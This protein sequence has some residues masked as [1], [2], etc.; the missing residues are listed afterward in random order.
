MR[1]AAFILLVL[2]LVAFA[3]TCAAQQ[4]IFVKRRITVSPPAELALHD[5]ALARGNSVSSLKSGMIAS[6]GSNKLAVAFVFSHKY[7]NH[8]HDS[9]KTVSGESFSK[10]T[11][12][13]QGDTYMR[14][15][16]WELKS[17]AFTSDTVQAWFSTTCDAGVFVLTFSGAD[18]VAY[19][20]S[21]GAYSSTASVNVTSQNGWLV[22]DGCVAFD[23]ADFATGAG[24]TAYFEE[25]KID[26]VT[27]L[28]FTSSRENGLTSVTMSHGLGSSTDWA[29]VGCSI[30]PK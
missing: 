24:Q 4:T 29:S 7:S 18:S 30:V 21:A 6:G 1:I 19:E 12:R 23:V 25:Y 5:T 20:T 16:L 2:V 27:G 14:V 3:Y 28:A 8:T 10:L 22:L 13:I 15:S 9:V 17:P 11:E 26:N